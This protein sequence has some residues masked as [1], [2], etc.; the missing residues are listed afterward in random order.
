MNILLWILQAILAFHTTAGAIWK[1][2]NSEQS[3]PSLSAIPHTVWLGMAVLEILCSIC[4]IVP[5]FYKPLAF[6]V[7]L[8]AA[9]I[10]LEMLAF[11]GLHL[12]ARGTENGQLIYWL[13][14]AAVCAF[15]VYG[16]SVLSPF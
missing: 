7:P 12:L 14:T 4:L 8:A 10:A 1:F 11:C 2:S 3:V 15:V 6:L 5:A 13:V 16:R 9:L